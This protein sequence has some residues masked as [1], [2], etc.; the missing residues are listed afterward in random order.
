MDRDTMHGLILLLLAALVAILAYVMI[1][2]RFDA[3]PSIN[4]PV[5]NAIELP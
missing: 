3:D 1:N 2:S 4:R 5:P